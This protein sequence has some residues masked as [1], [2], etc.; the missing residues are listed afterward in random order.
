M[1]DIDLYD[2]GFGAVLNCAVR[3]CLGRATYMPGLVCGYITPLLPYLNDKTLWCF[4]ED[5]RKHQKS[6]RSFGM[7]IDEKTWMD[8]YK[9][10]TIEE[11]RR[12]QKV[13]PK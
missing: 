9:A 1:M 8:F 10:V 7:D 12:K 6:G 13:H 2:D 5:I 3:Y 11:T 4:S